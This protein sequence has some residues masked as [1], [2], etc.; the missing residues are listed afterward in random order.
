MKITDVKPAEVRIKDDGKPTYL[1]NY[2]R[3]HTDEGVY[4]TG[5]ASHL[6][7]GWRC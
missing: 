7:G 3:I 4:G 1:Y 6:D 5:E 2:V